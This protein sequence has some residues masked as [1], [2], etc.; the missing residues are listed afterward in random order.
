MSGHKSQR[1]SVIAEHDIEY[2]FNCVK[3]DQIYLVKFLLKSTPNLISTRHGFKKETVVHCCRSVKMLELILEKGGSPSGVDCQWDSPLTV[4]STRSLDENVQMI[5]ML[6]DKGADVNQKDI[7]KRNALY[8]CSFHLTHVLVGIGTSLNDKDCDGNTPLQYMCEALSSILKIHTMVE[9]GADPR[10]VSNGKTAADIL[11]GNRW[12]FQG[13][14]DHFKNTIAI[15]DAKSRDLD[16]KDRRDAAWNR[17]REFALLLF[18][19]GPEKCY[20]KDIDATGILKTVKNIIDDGV[21]GE[22]Y[23]LIGQGKEWG[24]MIIEYM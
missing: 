5:N 24:R 12:H 23:K 16:E 13:G 15:L 11:R 1:M 7:L 6:V 17:R 2:F 19:S 21:S 20:N 4:F 14:D 10:I 9:L 8:Y 22:G 18:R 3:N